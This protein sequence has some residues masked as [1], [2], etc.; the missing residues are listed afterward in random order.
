MGDLPVTGLML[1][2]RLDAGLHSL[3]ASG[4]RFPEMGVL[5]KN[6]LTIR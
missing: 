1:L 2:E 3:L 5:K 6:H 4:Q